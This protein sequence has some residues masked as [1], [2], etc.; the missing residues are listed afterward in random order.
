M[1]FVNRVSFRFGGKRLETTLPDQHA[2]RGDCQSGNRNADRCQ[3]IRH[4][5]SS[6]GTGPNRKLENIIGGDRKH[7]ARSGDTRTQGARSEPR[8]RDCGRIRIDRS[9]KWWR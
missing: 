9:Q 5:G 6:R 8:Q 3:K 7:D 1:T 2:R 4:E